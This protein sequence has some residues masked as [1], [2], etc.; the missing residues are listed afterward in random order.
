MIEILSIFRFYLFGLFSMNVHLSSGCSDVFIEI[1]G[2][3]SAS[4]V[5]GLNAYDTALVVKLGSS[6]RRQLPLSY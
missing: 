3:G 5:I 2:N 1:D 4:S 6:M